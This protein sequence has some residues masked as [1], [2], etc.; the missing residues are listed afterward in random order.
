MKKEYCLKNERV[1]IALDEKGRIF[2][3]K[4][5]LTDNEFIN[6]KAPPDNFKLLLW[7][8]KDE[9]GHRHDI[10]YLMGKDQVPDEIDYTKTK[11]CF[12]YNSLSHKNDIYKISVEFCVKLI[13]DTFYFE[14]KIKNEQKFRIREAW[15]PLV[16]G[17]GGIENEDG[18]HSIGYVGT[19]DKQ[20]DV[21]N[22]PFNKRSMYVFCVEEETKCMRYPHSTEMPWYTLCNDEQGLY[23]ASYDKTL[24]LNHFRIEK[25]PA[26][27][28]G[29]VFTKW[30]K[31][32]PRH[33]KILCG[34]LVTIDEG[35]EFDCAPF[36]IVPYKG[37]WHEA[38]DRY[39]A[40]TDT[41]HKKP[42]RP[43]FLK[44]YTGWQHLLG[45]T[46][47]NEI[48]HTFESAAEIAVKAKELSG[49]NLVNFYGFDIAGAESDG[50][51]MYPAKEL[52][53]EEGFRELCRVLHE[54][55][56]KIIVFSHRHFLIDMEDDDFEKYRDFTVR[57]RLGGI[58]TEVWYKTTI[59]SMS[60]YG[61]GVSYEGNGPIC[62]SICPYCD[63]WWESCLSELKNLVVMGC[64]GM[65]F[66]LLNDGMQICY[67]DNHGHKPG[68]MPYEKFQERLAWLSS[69][70][71][72]HAP[73][74]I[75]A[76]EE[77][78]DVYYQYFDLTYSRYREADLGDEVYKYT[79]PDIIQN[80]AVDAYSYHQANKAFFLG[81][82]MGT[83]PYILKKNLTD[84]PGFAGYLGE[85]N[86][87]RTE[88]A[89][90]LMLGTF[91][92]DKDVSVSDPEVRATLYA[93]EHHKCLVLWNDTDC[94]KQIEV[95]V[96]GFNSS[97]V[98]LSE[99]YQKRQSIAIKDK[100]VMKPQGILVLTLL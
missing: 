19:Q 91:M 3:L 67:A 59:E 92:S 93:G 84:F 42:V 90:C 89:E 69:E 11:V 18:K 77:L 28:G 58:R 82:G 5:I 16:G 61:A 20:D 26:E 76:G 6:E 40:W 79:R 36:V 83:E 41:W 81:Y 75:L 63:E 60:G 21:L 85:L 86:K 25:T 97:N 10:T 39:R 52:G 87:I 73:E 47:Y 15:Y 96:S 51:R 70:I 4:N 99:P 48:Y 24:N 49:I 1:S 7:T 14:M 17:L 74:F 54:N 46:Y 43:E 27:G 22:M 56:M 94:A 95:S 32:V 30:D 29:P 57:D 64:D 66:D 8:H 88:N 62:A 2:S 45:K 71:K 100:L 23:V 34:K 50:S 55:D 31:D 44:K 37:S 78:T 65:Q 72:K 68:I 80:V 33:L 13:D 9:P 53:G 35:E 38:A 12:R 98:V